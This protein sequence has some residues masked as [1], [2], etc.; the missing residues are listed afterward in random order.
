M[1][2]SVSR[3]ARPDRRHRQRFSTKWV[4]FE[5]PSTLGRFRRTVEIDPVDGANEPGTERY[6]SRQ[7]AEDVAEE[8]DPLRRIQLG[9]AYFI[10]PAARGD[11][12]SA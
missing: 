2:G 10:F 7:R 8:L 11:G 9:R 4:E 12:R 5:D 6:A 3:R 1:G